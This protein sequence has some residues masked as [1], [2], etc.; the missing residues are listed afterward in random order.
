MRCRH[1]EYY[2]EHQDLTN[3]LHGLLPLKKYQQNARALC[4]KCRQ[5]SR[6]VTQS[7]EK[8]EKDS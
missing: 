2:D 5:L 4:T 8:H 3:A 7:R 6:G 1:S